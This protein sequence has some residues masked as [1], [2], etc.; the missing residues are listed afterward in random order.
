[1]YVNHVG[2]ISLAQM[3][4]LLSFKVLALLLILVRT[5]F[6]AYQLYNQK[7]VNY[8][9]CWEN[10]LEVAQC[11]STTIFLFRV[12]GDEC[13]CPS[14]LEWQAGIVSLALSSLVL[15]LWTETLPWIG[16][17]VIIMK[18]IVYSFLKVALFGLLL[19]IAFG[20]AFYMLFYRPSNEGVSYSDL[21]YSTL[22]AISNFSKVYFCYCCRKILEF[23][24]TLSE[25]Y[26]LSSHWLLVTYQ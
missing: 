3:R 15:I 26:W 14:T 10:W 25:Q 16:I 1:M 22:L 8:V 2:V 5:L 4:L 13:Y 7:V 12:T 19:I 11:L 24:V 9:L 6:E 23:T 21:V 20:L 17:Y 18:K